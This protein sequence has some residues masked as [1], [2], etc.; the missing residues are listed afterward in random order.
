MISAMNP[1]A[2]P[3]SQSSSFI[4]IYASRSIGARTTRATVVPHVAYGPQDDSSNRIEQDRIPTCASKMVDMFSIK[5]RI[6]EGRWSI[7]F[8]CTEIIRAEKTIGINATWG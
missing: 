8:H 3:D 5:L 7:A 2:V 6:L 4:A 1:R